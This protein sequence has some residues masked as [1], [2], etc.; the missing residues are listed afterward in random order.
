MVLSED[1]FSKKSQNVA[2]YCK[3]KEMIY[4]LSCVVWAQK[5]FFFWENTSKNPVILCALVNKHNQ[6]SK[7]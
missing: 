4:Q 5:Y 3:Q 2:G 1:S 6:I 7:W